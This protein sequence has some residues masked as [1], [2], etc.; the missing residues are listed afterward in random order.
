[1]SVADRIRRSRI[2]AG[3][4]TAKEAADALRKPYPTYAGHENGSRGIKSGEITLYAQAFG[5]SEHWLVFGTTSHRRRLRLVGEINDHTMSEIDRE[6]EIDVPFD[7]PPETV[8][9]RFKDSSYEPVYYAG[10]IALVHQRPLERGE[11]I[12]AIAETAS[13]KLIV[14]KLL[15]FNAPGLCHFQLATGQTL[16]DVEVNWVKKIVGLV[17]D[18]QI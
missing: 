18:N 2:A 5:V 4:R 10:E 12:R 1:M 8:A 7:C 15:K 13:K 9:L 14:G 11:N 3:Y 16:L 6:I 17:G